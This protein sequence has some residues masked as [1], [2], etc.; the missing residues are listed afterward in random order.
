MFVSVPSEGD[1]PDGDQHGAPATVSLQGQVLIAM[2]PPAMVD[3]R[4]ERSV[5]YV[6]S[7]SAHG[8]MGLVINKPAEG[9]NFT[10]LLARLDIDA[11]A[12]EADTLQI[13]AGGPVETNRGFVLHSADY[14]ATQPISNGIGLTATL[15][16]LR[17][18]AEGTGPT[19]ALLALGYAGW[20]P[21]Q[22]EGE[23]KANGWLHGPADQDLLF[24]TPCG[25]K[26]G[27]AMDALGISPSLLSNVQ[28]TA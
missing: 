16:I 3:Q 18:I 17:A 4:F 1:R 22:L 13:H 10:D 24:A 23:M 21:G 7:H 27:K 9:L 2:P 20:G 14:P 25:H 28:G 15:D 11:T 6:C 5:I 12:P 26:W 19:H 8:A